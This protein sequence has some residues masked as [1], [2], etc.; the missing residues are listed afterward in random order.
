M[1]KK[2][3]S[4]ISN[5]IRSFSG[6]FLTLLGLII[7]VWTTFLISLI[8]GLYLTGVVLL[9]IGILIDLRASEFAKRMTGR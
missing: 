6:D 9:V 7:I 8:A 1:F 5:F 2:I 4:F 3:L